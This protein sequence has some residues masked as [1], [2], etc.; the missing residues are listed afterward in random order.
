MKKLEMNQMETLE[1][2]N[3]ADGACAVLG[4]AGAGAGVGALVGT[5]VITG[6]GAA[7]LAVGGAACLAYSIWN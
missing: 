1:G 5:L 4:F 2:G 3:F 7:V 6:W